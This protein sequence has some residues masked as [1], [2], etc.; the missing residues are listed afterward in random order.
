MDDY[1]SKPLRRATRSTRCC[2][3]GS[4]TT[5]ATVIDRA[6]LRALARDVGDEAIVEEI[7]DLFLAETGPRLLEIERAAHGRAT[8]TLLRVSAH[9]L[10]GSARRMSARSRSRARRPSWSGS[11]GRA[12][13]ASCRRR[14]C[15]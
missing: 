8:P 1:L 11:R 4:G 6:V 2:S 14:C 5:E 3:A 9:T 12:S 15:G 13:S 10:K 7:C